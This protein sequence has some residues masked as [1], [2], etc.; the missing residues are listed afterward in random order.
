MHKHKRLYSQSVK[1]FRNGGNDLAVTGFT[2]VFDGLL[3][4]TS[5]NPAASLNPA[6]M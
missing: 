1:A 3:A 6:L 5:G 2:S 4:D